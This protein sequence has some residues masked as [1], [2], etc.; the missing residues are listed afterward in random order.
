LVPLFLLHQVNLVDL[1]VQWHRLHQD[2]PVV[3]WDL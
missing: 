3:L 1:L 2:Y